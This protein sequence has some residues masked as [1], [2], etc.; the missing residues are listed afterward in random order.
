[1]VSSD[2]KCNRETGDPMNRTKNQRI[3]CHKQF[4]ANNWEL[5]A[6]FA[7]EH[8]LEEGRGMVIVPEEDILGPVS[9]DA[10]ARGRP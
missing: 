8:F 4:I 3:D 2:L 7:W 6:A 10:H 9:I 1:M 5:I